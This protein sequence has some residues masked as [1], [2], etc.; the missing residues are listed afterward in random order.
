MENE[1]NEQRRFSRRA[2]RHKSEEA[3][4]RLP[5]EEEHKPADAAGTE[6]GAAAATDRAAGAGT[7]KTRME[8]DERPENRTPEIAQRQ[9]SR[10]PEQ[11]RR[12]SEAPYGSVNGVRMRPGT[13][14]LTATPRPA[15]PGREAYHALSGQRTEVRQEDAGEAND[16][17]TPGMGREAVRPVASQR[18]GSPENGA[19]GSTSRI[20]VGYAPGRMGENGYTRQISSGS[21]SQRPMYP[22]ERRM[23]P[24]REEQQP[25]PR[26]GHPVLWLL[27][28]VL[29]LVGMMVIALLMLPEKNGLRKTGED[30]AQKATGFIERMAE[31]K[32]AVPV[33]VTN[34][35]VNGNLNAI[36][37]ADITFSIST[38]NEAID[39][40]LVD[41]DGKPME[42]SVI[43]ANNTEDVVWLMT[44]HVEKGYSGPVR[45]QTRRSGEVWRDT[46]LQAEVNVAPKPAAL[47]EQEGTETSIPVTPTVNGAVISF[48]TDTP[49]PEPTATP[50]PVP[51]DT[52]AP[53]ETPT[54]APTDTPEP[55]E[56]PTATPPLTAEAAPAANPEA[57]GMTTT[58]YNGANRVKEYSRP[59]KELIHMPVGGEYTKK[60]LGVLTFRGDAFRKNA[61]SGTVNG[62]SSLAIRW[63]AEAA[64]VRGSGTTYYGIGW[65]GQPVIVKWSKQVR[66][67]SNFYE[68]KAEKTGLKEVIIAGLDGVIRFLDLEDGKLTRNNINLGYP[69]RGTPSVHPSGYPYMNV[70]QFAR[71]MKVKTGKIGLRQY[72]LYSQKELAL[73]DGL[74]GKNHRAINDIG[75]FETSALIDRTSDTVIT[76]GTNGMLYLQALNSNFD[77]QAGVYTMQ[78]SSTVMTSKTKGQKKAQVAVESSV[79]MYDRYVY[80][81]DMGGILRCVDTNILAPVWAVDTGDAVMATVALDLN[82]NRELALYTANMLYN[83]KKGNVQIRRYDALTGREIWTREVPVAKD[84]KDKVDVGVKASP[85]VGE[86]RLNELVYF[87]VTGASDE[88]R[89]TLGL[90]EQDVA[91]LLALDKE[92]GEV[93]WAVGLE[94]RTESSP[95]AVYD[96]EGNGW[97]IQCLQNGKVLLLEGLTG[98]ELN[99]LQ[100]EGEI[101][102]S[103]AVYNG[104]MVVGTT[105]KGTEHIYGIDIRE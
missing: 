66:E 21:A 53:T 3:Q 50:T 37:P 24:S 95:V 19:A 22:P 52:P 60:Q 78:A 9:D 7:G 42:T 38:G 17:R 20:R 98:K 86:N 54:Q 4:E 14:P 62:A 75:S 70:G 85:V 63:M 48:T 29:L 92:T 100:L 40:R 104:I 33:G 71:K 103:P 30:L 11:A 36:A 61:A 16:G 80:Y 32:A 44:L 18:P 91:A 5:L 58:I 57:L 1:R 72:N 35:T 99:Q 88:G 73:I 79:A 90:G 82:E 83:R 51:T 96:G 101:E 10:I 67:S 55:T 27:A 13:R 46:E 2:D 41:Q 102:G 26:T 39:L 12:M 6:S 25:E 34:F 59:A 8:Q 31:K 69:M 56:E 87:T 84:A 77:W 64:S 15:S 28:G 43:Q 97:I 93:K 47:D 68:S 76:A 105:G 94:S 23:V 65:T 45:L 49:T 81:A 89:E 74:D